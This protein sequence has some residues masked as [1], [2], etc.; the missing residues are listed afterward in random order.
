MIGIAGDAC[1]IESASS[2][3]IGEIEHISIVIK[4]VDH[5][6]GQISASSAKMKENAGQLADLAQMLQ[7]LIGYFRLRS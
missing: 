5:T 2:G 7:D 1:S 6:S 3:A 4:E